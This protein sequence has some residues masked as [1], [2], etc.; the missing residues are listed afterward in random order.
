M[1]TSVWIVRLELDG[2]VAS[3]K[4]FFLSLQVLIHKFL[5]QGS[6]ARCNGERSYK[7]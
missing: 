7:I 4:D 5:A 3:G 6:I 1:L 2:G